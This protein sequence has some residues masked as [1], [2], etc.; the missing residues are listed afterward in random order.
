MIEF[1]FGLTDL[2][3]NN[4][5]G[6]VANGITGSAMFIVFRGRK[7]TT[8]KRQQIQLQIQHKVDQ[9]DNDN[10]DQKVTYFWLIK[11]FSVSRIWDFSLNDSTNREYN[12]LFLTKQYCGPEIFPYRSGQSPLCPYLHGHK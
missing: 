11:K 5:T 2:I 12:I 10:D 6:R 9:K 3:I 8:I 7:K 4:S 1:N